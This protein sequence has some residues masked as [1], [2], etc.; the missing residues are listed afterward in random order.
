MVLIRPGNTDMA[1]HIAFSCN[2]IIDTLLRISVFLLK[3]ADWLYFI[4]AHGLNIRKHNCILPLNM[5]TLELICSL[6]V[7]P[8]A[9]LWLFY[10]QCVQQRGRQVQ[11]LHTVYILSHPSPS[12]ILWSWHHNAVNYC[13]MALL[14]CYRLI[15]W[16]L[17]GE[18][19][20]CESLWFPPLVLP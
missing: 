18:L 19:Y 14:F 3:H 8:F 13:R 4:T 1:Y 15:S 17:Y 16:A 11:T 12:Q 6:E 7:L 5:L 10:N 2:T 20:Q 9:T